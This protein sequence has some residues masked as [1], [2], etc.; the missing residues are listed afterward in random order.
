MNTPNRNL[1][2]LD[3]VHV[4]VCRRGRDCFGRVIFVLQQIS[5]GRPLSIPHLPMSLDCFIARLTLPRAS[6]IY[7]WRPPSHRG[8]DNHQGASF[9]RRLVRRSLPTLV[10]LRRA[11]IV[12]GISCPPRQGVRRSAGASNDNTTC[13]CCGKPSLSAD[14]GAS[15]EQGPFS[16]S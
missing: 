5:P 4:P 8:N 11:C 15:R 12:L 9:Y 7:V 16:K 10:H 14:F 2:G 1:R 6:S 3:S 13:S